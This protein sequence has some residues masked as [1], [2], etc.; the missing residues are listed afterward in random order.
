MKSNIGPEEQLMIPTLISDG[1]EIAKSNLKC[2]MPSPQPMNFW[3]REKCNTIA[4]LNRFI[5]CD[6]IATLGRLHRNAATSTMAALA[7]RSS[8]IRDLVCPKRLPE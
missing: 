6:V 5:A 7:S 3:L 8:L 4:I 2:R 1:Q